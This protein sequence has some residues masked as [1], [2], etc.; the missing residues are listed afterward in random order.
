MRAPADRTDDR[1]PVFRQDPICLFR[2]ALVDDFGPLDAGHAFQHRLHAIGE[3][4]AQSK[5][6]R[7]VP[8]G[9][10]FQLRRR[11]IGDYL[12]LGDDHGA[13]THR[14]D[15]FQHVRGQ[16]NGLFPRHGFDEPAHFMF[17]VGIEPVGRFVENQ[18]GRIMHYG[19][20]QAHPPFESLG[21]GVNG[22]M[23]H[24]LEI[25]LF[26]GL[27]HPAL[28][29]RSTKPAH[30]ADEPQKTQRRHLSIGRGSFRQIPQAFF[31]LE[32]LLL[33]I[34]AVDL[35]GAPG[36]GQKPRNHFHGRGF[37]RAVGP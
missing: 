27:R 36:R 31:G 11:A 33:H 20:G 13:R 22:L 37:S 18:H 7:I 23:R 1:L 15:F 12:A 6:H 17:L 2:L 26:H 35:D 19:L 10:G 5:D 24:T 9:P 14:V 34:E 28:Q 32:R 8:A 4:P 16:N 29:L 25:H 3:R 21:E 30:F